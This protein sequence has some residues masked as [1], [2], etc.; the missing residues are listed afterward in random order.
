VG[1]ALE[2][3]DLSRQTQ[4]KLRETEAL[5][6]VSRALSSTLDQATLFRHFLR[7]VATTL[8]ADSVGLW[9]L[10]K[11][12]ERLDPH[13]A[14]HLPRHVTETV[15]GT[16]LSIAEHEFYAEAV[17]TLR[18]VFSRDVA[19]DPRIP[20]W[21]NKLV[22]HR[23]QLFVPIVSRGRFI[24]G[25]A[26]VWWEREPELSA[27]EV[28]LMEAIANQ[29]AIAIS[30]VGLFEENRRQV[31]ELSVLYELS[32]AVTGQLDRAALLDTV[33]TQMARVLDARQMIAM[34][35][36]PQQSEFEVVFRIADG[37]RQPA[38]ERYPL[39]GVGL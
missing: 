25:F 4:V 20:A 14:Y 31:E 6:S 17:R 30:N 24:G 29:A 22:P 33:A 23:S 12:G 39:H 1:L 10:G 2:N 8:G 3:A 35:I 5:L 11:D 34:L 7:R 38:Q 9:L 32:R 19:T 36:D 37:V 27:S 26:A 18:P 28:D 16:R 21:A 15:R 13:A